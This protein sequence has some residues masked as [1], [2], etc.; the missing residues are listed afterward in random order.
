MSILTRQTDDQESIRSEEEIVYRRLSF[1]D[2]LFTATVY[3]RNYRNPM[4]LRLLK[5][6]SR[7]DSEDII[8]PARIGHAH[9]RGSREDKPGSVTNHSQEPIQSRSLR[10]AHLP[11]TA[12]ETHQQRKDLNALE[13]TSEPPSNPAYES[14][15]G[16]EDTEDDETLDPRSA[17]LAERPMRQRSASSNEESSRIFMNACEQGDLTTVQQFLKIGHDMQPQQAYPDSPDFGAIHAAAM[18]GHIEIVQIL[19]QYGASI[20]DRTTSIGSQ[21]LHLAAQS[22]DTGMIQFLLRNGAKIAAKNQLG[23]QPIHLAARSGSIETLRI[24]VGEGAALDCADDAGRQPL[25]W[26]AIFDRPDVIKYLVKADAD[27]NARDGILDTALQKVAVSHPSRLQVSQLLLA[28]ILLDNNANCDP[29][30]LLG[31][32]PLYLATNGHQHAISTLLIESGARYLT[33]NS[34]ETLRLHVHGSMHDMLYR[35]SAPTFLDSRIAENMYEEALV[36]RILKTLDNLIA[37]GIPVRMVRYD[38]QFEDDNEISQF[39]RMSN[40]IKLL[41][42]RDPRT[43]LSKRYESPVSSDWQKTLISSYKYMSSV[44]S[45]IKPSPKCAV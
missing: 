15:T 14:E 23:E 1:E 24:L 41:L 34:E 7:K 12:Q 43:R 37:S 22:G 28:Q 9:I 36:R 2:D 45:A 39:L 10:G 31:H 5:T 29:L 13:I 6:E 3:K 11:S 16:F 32:T 20:E 33:S 8:L 40:R 35:F 27:I 19:L 17:R 21:P 42:D 26:A 18:Y 30:D 4:L 38:H 25:H 44:S